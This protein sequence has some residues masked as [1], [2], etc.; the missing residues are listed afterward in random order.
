MLCEIHGSGTSTHYAQV[1]G[2]VGD[3][4]NVYDTRPG[5]AGAERLERCLGHIAGDGNVY[6]TARG[7][8]ESAYQCVGHIGAQGRIYSVSSTQGEPIDRC[9][10]HVE[11]DGSVYSTPGPAGINFCVG[12]ARGSRSD[13][14]AA[15]LLLL[16]KASADA[17]GAP[18]ASTS[19]G[20]RPSAPRKIYATEKDL[21]KTLLVRFAVLTVIGAALG[22]LVTN[23]DSALSGLFGLLVGAALALMSALGGTNVVFRFDASRCKSALLRALAGNRGIWGTVVPVVLLVGAVLI[24]L[25]CLSGSA[26]IAIALG[27]VAAAA[28]LGA[29]VGT[30]IRKRRGK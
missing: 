10:G 4:G 13:M 30:A 14:G 19:A 5:E 8:G 15:A 27:A 16:I 28:A 17:G 11:P 3:D 12:Q 1:V 6:N 26:S 9:V 25:C 24:A 18:S 20:G 29:W 23:G 21:G 22:N 2:H 7:F